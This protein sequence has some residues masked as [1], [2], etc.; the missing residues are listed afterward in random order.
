ML[1]AGG[2]DLL[3]EVNKVLAVVVRVEERP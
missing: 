3:G 2:N 1:E